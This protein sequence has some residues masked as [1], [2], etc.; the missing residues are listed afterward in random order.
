MTREE[1]IEMMKDLI[2]Q[3]REEENARYNEGIHFCIG[4]INATMNKCDIKR[5]AEVEKELQNV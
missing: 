5:I 1:I 2:K 4:W 3:S